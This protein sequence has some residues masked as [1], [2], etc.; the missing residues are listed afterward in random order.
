MCP[1]G[2]LQT[3]VECS[4]WPG[5]KKFSG[6]ALIEKTY[7]AQI[8]LRSSAPIMI[9]IISRAYIHLSR[10]SLSLSNKVSSTR[11]SLRADSQTAFWR[12]AIS[13]VYKYS[14]LV[15]LQS[16]LPLY[17]RHPNLDAHRHCLRTV[18]LNTLMM[19]SAVSPKKLMMAETM[20]WLASIRARLDYF[21]VSLFRNPSGK[22]KIDR[23]AFVLAD[24]EIPLYVH[25]FN[26]ALRRLG[27][28]LRRPW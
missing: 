7:F 20:C 22:F 27:C 26:L 2:R 25:A 17:W 15:C 9:T 14:D 13:T 18:S 21:R 24:C 5:E 3:Q 16:L 23:C 10:F 11:S 8:Y 19:F 28:R 6:S 4:T 12:W 1:Y